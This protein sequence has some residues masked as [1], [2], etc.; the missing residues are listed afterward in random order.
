[1]SGVKSVFHMITTEKK[2]KKK[3]S[4]LGRYTRLLNQLLGPGPEMPAYVAHPYQKRHSCISLI[5]AA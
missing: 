2:K 4:V 3:K 1:M 5:E